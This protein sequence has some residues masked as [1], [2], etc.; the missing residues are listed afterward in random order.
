MGFLNKVISKEED[1]VNVENSLENMKNA[2]LQIKCERELLY[3]FSNPNIN[4]DKKTLR[5]RIHRLAAN[6]CKKFSFNA[7]EV[8]SEKQQLVKSL[9]KFLDPVISYEEDQVNVE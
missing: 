7:S 3:L 2:Y 4:K 6:D 5:R 8:E 9:K 1:Q